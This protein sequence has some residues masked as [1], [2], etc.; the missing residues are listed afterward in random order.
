MYSLMYVLMNAR[1]LELLKIMKVWIIDR[2]HKW[3]NKYIKWLRK[4]MSF[5]YELNFW[6][7]V[8]EALASN[9]QFQ[10]I[11]LSSFNHSFEAYTLLIPPLLCSLDFHI[12]FWGFPLY[13]GYI[14]NETNRKPRDYD[15]RSSTKRIDNFD[16]LNLQL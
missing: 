3:M 8:K 16:K 5:F 1:A 9:N 14:H 13:R 7:I 2:L 4:I 12:T 15:P 11:Y 6:I 10:Q